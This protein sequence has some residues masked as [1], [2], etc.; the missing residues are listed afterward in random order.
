MSHHIAQI[1][2]G[3]GNQ[4][5]NDS[6]FALRFSPQTTSLTYS[7][8][9]CK[10]TLLGL[11]HRGETAGFDPPAFIDRVSPRGKDSTLPLLTF[12]TP[13]HPDEDFS[14]ETAFLLS[15]AQNHFIEFPGQESF[16][17]YLLT[18]RQ[19]THVFIITANVEKRYLNSVDRMEVSQDPR[20]GLQVLLSKGFNLALVE[21]RKSFLAVY[22]E[23][24]MG[25]MM[26]AGVV[27]QMAERLA[28]RR[29]TSV[30]MDVGM[31][32]DGGIDD[33]DDGE[34]TEVDDYAPE[35]IRDMLQ[36][37]ERIRSALKK[38]RWY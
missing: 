1:W 29:N 17:P 5:C 32:D 6:A 7:G 4:T 24:L 26:R 22:R 19:S 10:R 30:G 21:D 13:H 34:E 9:R 15:L 12:T 33:M 37:S 18:V 11:T 31:D 25:L 14:Y 8:I 27:E 23:L 38:A 35:T 3:L 16:Q 2:F 36:E 20:D 28:R